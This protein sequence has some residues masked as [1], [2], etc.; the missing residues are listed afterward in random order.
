MYTLIISKDKEEIREIARK[1]GFEVADKPDSQDFYSGDIN[2]IIQ[3]A[4]KQGNFVDKNGKVLGIHQGIWNFTIGQ[5][6]GLGVSA[7]KPLYVIGLNK[8]KNEVVLGYIDESFKKGLKAVDVVWSA[9][10]PFEGKRKVFA[11]V[12]SSQTP[13]EAW[14]NLSDGGVQIEFTEPQKALAKGQSVVM[15]DDNE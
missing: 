7:D 14:A 11:K 12:R 3:T 9:A 6:R 15:Y 2:D 10:Q 13:T 1:N 4:P 5:R 8:E